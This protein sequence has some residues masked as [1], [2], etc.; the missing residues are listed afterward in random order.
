MS[1]EDWKNLPQIIR[2]F[3]SPVALKVPIKAEK[4]KRKVTRF[5]EK[6]VK[7]EH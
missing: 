2:V 7:E 4:K 5:L 1:K 6:Y 3:F